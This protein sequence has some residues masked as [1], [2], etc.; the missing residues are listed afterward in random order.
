VLVCWHARFIEDSLNL[1][2]LD[3]LDGLVEEVLKL[4]LD[5]LLL[6]EKLVNVVDSALLGSGESGITSS[7][8]DS[9]VLFEPCFH[10][11]AARIV[12]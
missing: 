3:L 2:L 10:F 1:E 6:V 11:R 8:N 5:D 7:V 12:N 4:S 9:L